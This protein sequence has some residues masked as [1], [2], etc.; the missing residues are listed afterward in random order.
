MIEE[1]VILASCK[2]GIDDPTK[3]LRLEYLLLESWQRGHLSGF[4]RTVS[5]SSASGPLTVLK[6]QL[7][8]QSS[9]RQTHSPRIHCLKQKTEAHASGLLFCTEILTEVYKETQ[10]G[11]LSERGR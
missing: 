6:P 8:Q 11:L 9:Q 2:K 5:V 3:I 1:T 4:E 10:L 7:A